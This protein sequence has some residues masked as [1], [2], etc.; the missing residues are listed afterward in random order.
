[1][2]IE[3]IRDRLRLRI[4]SLTE[5]GRVGREDGSRRRRMEVRD[6]RGL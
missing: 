6:R 5:F 4:L 1:V 3:W 2:V